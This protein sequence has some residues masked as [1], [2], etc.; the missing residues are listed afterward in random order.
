MPGMDIEAI[1]HVQLAMPPG[2]ENQARNFYPGVL[3]LR[4]VPKPR[5]LAKRGIGLVI[6]AFP[7]M[8]IERTSIWEAAA[9]R[10]GS[11]P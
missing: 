2:Q 10:R 8:G 4:E 5:E 6:T 7:S 3:S 9:R 11:N 1:E